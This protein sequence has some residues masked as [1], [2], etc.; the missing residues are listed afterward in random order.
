MTIA[1]SA[2]TNPRNG[3][4]RHYINGFWADMLGLNIDRYKSGNI[5]S[6]SIDG[7]HISN[8]R[9]S[10]LG[11]KL[12]AD[13]QGNLHLDYFNG[14]DFYTQAEAL[15]R[16]T[17]Y[18]AEHGGLDFLAAEDEEQQAEEAP[19][20]ETTVELTEE[21]IQAITTEKS[22]TAKPRRARRGGANITPTETVS[23]SAR[24]AEARGVEISEIISA[25]TARF[26]AKDFIQAKKIARS[27]AVIADQEKE[28]AEAYAE[29]EKVMDL[30]CFDS[31]TMNVGERNE[32]LEEAAVAVEEFSPVAHL[33][34]HY[35]VA[36][37]KTLNRALLESDY[38]AWAQERFA[39]GVEEADFYDGLAGEIAEA[40]R[41]YIR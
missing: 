17:K 4:T 38:R 25:Y 6:A 24:I 30:I 10:R 18:I 8:G 32:A 21:E 36:R 34:G 23:A 14:D 19:A 31:D 26:G 41:S 22:S 11:G 5:R 27:Q 40:L 28:A 13:E 35:A 16:I 37:H 7:E 9:A 15:E 3:E 20:T 33:A 39:L 2:W 1:T 29:A 12:W